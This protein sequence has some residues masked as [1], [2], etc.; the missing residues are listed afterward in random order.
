MFPFTF[1]P[2]FSV[3]FFSVTLFSS[4]FMFGFWHFKSF[5]LL[6]AFS[7]AEESSSEFGIALLSASFSAVEIFYGR[8]ESWCVSQ[9]LAFATKP[10]TMIT[11]RWQTLSE[12]E[13]RRIFDVCKRWTNSSFA[14]ICKEKYDSIHEA[15][16][17][18]LLGLLYRNILFYNYSQRTLVSELSR[19][20]RRKQ[21]FH[22][23]VL[24]LIKKYV[25]E[26]KNDRE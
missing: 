1:R 14:C 9:P 6:V 18:I 10:V 15:T 20:A 26:K 4:W 25:H 3:T 5:F 7:E 19:F 21:K 17:A 16:R 8:S 11:W 13:L 23:A 24:L 2:S 22:S 12:V